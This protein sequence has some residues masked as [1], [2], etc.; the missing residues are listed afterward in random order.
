MTQPYSFHF[1]MVDPQSYFNPNSKQFGLANAE[2]MRVGTTGELKLRGEFLEQARAVIPEEEEL[3]SQ[4]VIFKDHLVINTIRVSSPRR[5]YLYFIPLNSSFENFSLKAVKKIDVYNNYSDIKVKVFSTGDAYKYNSELQ[6]PG[7]TFL[8]INDGRGL[9]YVLS[10]AN[11]VFTDFFIRAR[12]DDNFR[13]NI[14]DMVILQGRMWFYTSPGQSIVEDSK[15]GSKF[16]A[17]EIN[18]LDNFA[19]TESPATTSF[20]FS[21]VTEEPETVF[22]LTPSQNVMLVATSQGVRIIRSRNPRDEGITSTNV[23]Q[24]ITS[25]LAC[26]N[27]EPVL[28]YSRFFIYATSA[29]LYYKEINRFEERVQ[30]IQ[31]E[32]VFKEKNI[33]AKNT[34]LLESKTT[35]S[36][37]AVMDGHLISSG[38]IQSSSVPY[39]FNLTNF[40]PRR[41]NVST[42]HYFSDESVLVEFDKS[43]RE[44]ILSIETATPKNSPPYRLGL[45]YYKNLTSIDLH[46]KI[47]GN[48]DHLIDM[49][50][51]SS[52]NNNVF[53]K[54]V[55]QKD[56]D[57][58]I[59]FSSYITG[60]T[61][62]EHS[63]YVYTIDIAV[64]PKYEK[65]VSILDAVLN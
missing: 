1:G 39:T 20:N 28:F 5:G 4:C 14:V 23:E 52:P 49:I 58:T 60:A 35:S 26:L 63:L 53:A 42:H 31:D 32:P 38:F 12:G 55:V 24:T 34:K 40:S 10:P 6:T 18:V 17:S 54:V 13:P 44:V 8:L 15:Y 56:I 41:S 51:V 29:G 37:Y 59:E 45:Y 11:P 43:S 64:D 50:Q 46:V 47:S 25:S 65:S 57:T 48:E 22:S 61:V 19:E 33:L 7:D 3:G 9:K 62:A 30:G 16:Y 36:F 2:N 27:V 21:L